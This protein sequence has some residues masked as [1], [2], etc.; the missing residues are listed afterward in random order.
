[1]AY[2]TVWER[3]LKTKRMVDFPTIDGESVVQELGFI[4]VQSWR[5]DWISTAELQDEIE[6]K[7]AMAEDGWVINEEIKRTAIHEALDLYSAKISVRRY[8]A[9]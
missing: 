5:F 8:S 1:M 2:S 3:P 9:T 4:E 6:L 7:E